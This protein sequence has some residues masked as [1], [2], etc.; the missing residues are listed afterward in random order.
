MSTFVI[1]LLIQFVCALAIEYKCSTTP[2]DSIIVTCGS[3]Y[4]RLIESDDYSESTEYEYF[5]GCDSYRS[6]TE[7]FVQF[8]N[9]SMAELPLEALH[10]ING[11]I[12][13]LNLSYLNATDLN[14]DQFLSYSFLFLRK[15]IVSFN[16]LKELTE[17]IFTST[18]LKYLDLSHNQFTD[19][20]S[21]GQSGANNLKILNISHNE[22]TI[23]NE[24]AFV[25]LSQL[26]LVDLSFNKLA[27]LS[28]GTFDMLKNLKELFLAYTNVFSIDFG[29]LSPL[30]N[31]ESLD[32]SGNHLK[33]ILI[34]S[35]SAIFRRL[36]RINMSSC[37][38]QEIS[39]LN[40]S[41]FPN[42]MNLDLTTNQLSCSQLISTLDSFDLHKL[43]L[44]TDPSS[45]IKE[46]KSYRGVA[47]KLESSESKNENIFL[48]TVASTEKI[49]PSDKN[50]ATKAKMDGNVDSFIENDSHLHHFKQLHEKLDTNRFMVMVVIIML[51]LMLGVMLYTNRNRFLYPFKRSQMMNRGAGRSAIYCEQSAIII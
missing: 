51:A 7:I 5:S 37:G 25:N 29:T 13:N 42:L 34:G 48:T 36:Q 28:D 41:I 27:N 2:S 9:C 17:N 15:L 21:I 50:N 39:G 20:D 44:E 19:M 31:L 22:I 8:Q 10:Q 38:I 46:G 1:F 26:E 4:S 24:I 45:K 3:A 33:K 40:H 47:C 16:M 32:I 43:E 18:E 35:H 6:T 14:A 30:K 12:Y 49:E 23:I 11:M